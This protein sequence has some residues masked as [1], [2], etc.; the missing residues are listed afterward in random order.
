MNWYNPSSWFNNYSASKAVPFIENNSKPIL[1]YSNRFNSF[2]PFIMKEECDWPNDKSGQ[3]SNDSD[4]PGSTTRFGIDFTSYH[5]D[6]PNSTKKDII[7]LTYEKAI[8]IY[9]EDYWQKHN[10]ESIS[11]SLGECMMNTFVNGGHPIEWQRECG[12]D[13]S[14]F[15]S[16]QEKY[17]K[18]LCAYWSK[19]GKHDPYKYLPGWLN[20]TTDLRKYL[21]LA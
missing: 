11:Y 18:D 10:I 14:K 8:N 19:N 16:L 21:K 2:M 17:Y 9:W 20:R 12:G 7:N 15:I 5:R 6:H 13:P 3:L 4:D 1:A